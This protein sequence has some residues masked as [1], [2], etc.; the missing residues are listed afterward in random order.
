MKL[1]NISV[2]ESKTGMFLFPAPLIMILLVLDNILR[3]ER[4]IFTGRRKQLN[5]FF[6]VGYIIIKMNS[7]IICKLF[8]L[9]RES[10]RLPDITSIYAN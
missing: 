2:K 8:E 1:Q 4:E 3:Q 6:L 7:K 10:A 9:T 5:L